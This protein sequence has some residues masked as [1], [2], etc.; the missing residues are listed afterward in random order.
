MHEIRWSIRGGMAKTQWR[1]NE[2]GRKIAVGQSVVK[3]EPLFPSGMGECPT[4]S[5]LYQR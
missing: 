1:G 4:P 2:E 3:T 5:Q